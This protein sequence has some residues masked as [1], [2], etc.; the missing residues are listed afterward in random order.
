MSVF[1]DRR[2]KS[3]LEKQKINAIYERNFDTDDAA[4]EIGNIYVKL[5]YLKFLAK[6]KP[7]LRAFVLNFD[8]IS[9]IDIDNSDFDFLAML[10][11]PP[12]YFD[13]NDKDNGDF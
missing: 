7:V 9:L 2:C 5:M 10:R 1:I 11:I 13:I 8:W 4:E 12:Y 6:M 3:I